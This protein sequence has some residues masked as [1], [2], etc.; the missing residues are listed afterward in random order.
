MKLK[1]LS[2]T[3]KKKNLTLFMIIVFSLLLAMT[4]SINGLGVRIWFQ[5]ILFFAQLVIVKTLLDDYYQE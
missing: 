3:E 5:V 2:K 1:E 4:S